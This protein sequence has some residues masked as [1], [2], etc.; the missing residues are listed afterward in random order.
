MDKKETC[1]ELEK[2]DPSLYYHSYIHR[3]ACACAKKWC[4]SVTDGSFIQVCAVSLDPHEYRRWIFTGN[5]FIVPIMSD[6]PKE[7]LSMTTCIRLSREY[8][9][10]WHEFHSLTEGFEL[11]CSEKIYYRV[12]NGDDGKKEII[13]W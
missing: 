8:H 1:D 10:N 7:R 13:K 9:Q 11:D 12:E 6:R 2:M 3:D 4:Y 5:V